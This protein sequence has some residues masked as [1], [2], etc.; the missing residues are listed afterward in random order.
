MVF[1]ELLC[2]IDGMKEFFKLNKTKLVFAFKF[3]S[4]VFL[5]LVLIIFGIGYLNGQVPELSLFLTVCAGAGLGLPMFMLLIATLRGTWDL[6]K[7]RKA[8]GSQPFS[9]LL[10]HGFTE[11]IKHDKNRWQFSEPI[12]TGQIANFQILVEVDTQQA[13]DVI[14]FQ[15]LTEV[16]VIGKNE[17]E[18]LA[19]QFSHD[20]IELDFDGVTK[21]ISIKNQR[22]TKIDELIT[23]LTRFILIIRQQNFKPVKKE[24]NK[25]YE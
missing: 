22:M 9:E 17:V 23:E 4:L 2:S 24:H 21:K 13:P 25:C 14:R 1:S 12:L 20:E 8:F 7:R 3:T 18:R 16:E 19:R 10:K 11:K 5:T 6:H 15:A